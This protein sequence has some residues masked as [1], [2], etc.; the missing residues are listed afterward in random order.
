MNAWDTYPVV[1][2]FNTNDDVVELLRIAF[3]QAGF[4]GVSGHID[5]LRRGTLDLPSFV[6]EHDPRVIV[7]D[8]APP[9]E[10]HWRFLQHIRDSPDMRGRAFVLTSTNVQRLYELVGTKEPIFELIGKPYDLER[11]TRAVKEAS[12]TRPLGAGHT[13][14]SAVSRPA[15]A[16]DRQDRTRGRKRPSPVDS[17]RRTRR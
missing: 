13:S 1:A 17:T 16:S 12:R 4:I 15:E 8:V 9:Y 3:E 10:N 2:I 11:I 14:P 6:R 7:Y 5:D